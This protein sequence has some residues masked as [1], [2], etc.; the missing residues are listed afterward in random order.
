MDNHEL[1]VSGT[2]NHFGFNM[3]TDYA[4]IERDLQTGLYDSTYQYQY[5]G[6]LEQGIEIKADYEWKP[7]PQSRFEAGYDYTRNWSNSEANA[8]NKLAD[9]TKTQE[10]YLYY[11]DFNGLTQNHALYVTYGNRFW[12]KLSIQVGL[13]GEY[14]MRHLESFYKDA[15]GDRQDSYAA[16]RS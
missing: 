8:F 9:G 2:Y 3:G 11:A 16:P 14:Y 10:L 12:D 5:S 4:Q 1:Y 6:N 13:R 15:A 7:T